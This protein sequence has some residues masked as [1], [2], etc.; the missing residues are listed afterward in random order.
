M[1]P[2]SGRLAAAGPGKSKQLS[3]PTILE[4]TA[5]GLGPVDSVKWPSESERP[6][7]TLEGRLPGTGAGWASLGK[8]AATSYPASQTPDQTSY[9]RLGPASP[10]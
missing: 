4:V 3:Q 10:V 8:W 9:L 6:A 1:G 7:A 2:G 5:V